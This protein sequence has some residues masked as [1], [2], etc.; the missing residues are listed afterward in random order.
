MALALGVVACGPTPNPPCNG[1]TGG[2]GTGG[3]GAAGGF[4]GTGGFG[5]GTGGPLLGV[6]GKPFEVTLTQFRLVTCGPG[7]TVDEVITEVFDPDNRKV[8]HTHTPVT[9]DFQFS[10]TISFTPTV[11]GSYHL[12]ARFEPSIGTAQVDVQITANRT[13]APS[14]MVTTAN[15]DCAALEVTQSGLVLCLKE[16]NNELLVYRNNALLQTVSADDFAVA[17]SI[18]WTTRLG[19]VKRFV[20]AT[21]G[22]PLTGAL[23]KDTYVNTIGTLLARE[24]E[25]VLSTNSETVAVRLENGSLIEDG[26]FSLTKLQPA[27]MVAGPD[28]SLMIIHGNSLAGEAGNICTTPRTS[29]YPACRFASRV[30]VLGADN[31]GIWSHDDVGLRHDAI[32]GGPDGGIRTTRMVLPGL[33]FDV[34][35]LPRHFEST[36]ILSVNNQAFLPSIGADGITLEAYDVEAG[37]TVKPSSSRTVRLQHTDGRQKLI[38]R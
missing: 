11:A 16:A 20:E 38:T 34:E 29:T 1:G 4:G 36:P 6:A 25:A 18:I 7:S 19:I 3:F 31:T 5:G 13:N 27:A 10:T 24:T 32:S 9:T 8:A 23:F 26:R 2:F 28:L 17:G 21:S 35:P 37:F 14:T 15:V 30:A 33:P 22:A 12:S